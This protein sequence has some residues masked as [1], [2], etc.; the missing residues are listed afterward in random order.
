MRCFFLL[1]AFSTWQV[2]FGQKWKGKAALNSSQISGKGDAESRDF[3]PIFN[4]GRWLVFSRAWKKWGAIDQQ[5]TR[6]L[7][8]A[9]ESKAEVH[10]KLHQWWLG[11]FG[12]FSPP[13]YSAQCLTGNQRDYVQFRHPDFHL[14]LSSLFL[15]CVVWKQTMSKSKDRHCLG[16]QND[17]SCL[18][19]DWRIIKAGWTGVEISVESSSPSASP[20]CVYP[21]RLILVFLYRTQGLMPKNRQVCAEGVKRGCFGRSYGVWARQTQWL[22]FW[23]QTC[24]K[25]GTCP[26]MELVSF[27]ASLWR[28]DL[29]SRKN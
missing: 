28:S 20:V 17:F 29:K 14:W 9:A 26:K 7:G 11:S 23:N 21:L 2:S 8:D 16:Q 13:A 10:F 15:S 3:S 27:L 4:K 19:L 6:F 5:R 18:L 22:N 12:S 25:K 24:R 1:L